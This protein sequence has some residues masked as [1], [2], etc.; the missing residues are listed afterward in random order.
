MIPIARRGEVLLMQ[1]FD[2]DPAEQDAQGSSTVNDVFHN[3]VPC[4]KANKVKDMF[5]IKSANMGR[6]CSS[7]ITA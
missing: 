2:L 1:R 7:G 6:S 5:P 3:G 4:R